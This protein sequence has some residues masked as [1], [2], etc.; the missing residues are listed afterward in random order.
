MKLNTIEIKLDIDASIMQSMQEKKEEFKKALL[1]YSA[2]GLYKKGKL[3]LGK[4]AALCNTGR[5]D[6]IEKVRC[7]GAAIF[8]YDNELI[9]D[10]ISKADWDPE[11]V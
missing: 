10:M 8:D 9:S 7:E 4:A 3:S 2:L 6:F 1:F 11:M 5:L